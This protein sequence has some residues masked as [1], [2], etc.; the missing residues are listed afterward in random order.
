MVVVLL[1]L[2]QLWLPAHDEAPQHSAVEE[3]G[4]P[5]TPHFPED[6]HAVNV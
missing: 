2:L 6:L 4:A 3:K 1:N 5:E